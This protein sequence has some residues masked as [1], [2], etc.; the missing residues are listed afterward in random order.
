MHQHLVDDDLEEQRRDQGEQLQE[1]RGDQ[2]LAQQAAVFVD[3]AQE[4]GD[5]EAAGEVRQAGAPRHQIEAAVPDRDELGPRHQVGP[6]RQRRLDQDLVVAGLAEDQE[7]AVAQRRDGGQGRRG[8]PRPVG[9][10]RARLEAE[11]LGAA[12]HFRC[13]DL[14]VP[15]RC[16]ICPGSAATPWK[17]SSVTRASSPGS[18]G[19]APSGSVLMRALR[20]TSRS[21]VRLR[22]QRRLVRRRIGNR[23]PALAAAGR[24]EARRHELAQQGGPATCGAGV[25]AL[26]RMLLPGPPSR[27]SCPPPPISTSSPLPPVSVSLPGLPIRT[28]SPSPPLAVS[29]MPAEP[30]RRR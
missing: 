9:P 27:T 25:A 15:S 21:G 24:D 6:R 5:V 29:S 19:L 1:E 8:E 20:G 3:R 16:L 13:A 14:V 11:I 22:Q 7:A 2:H 17:R 4:P 12:E 10:A 23:R 28:S 18:A 30:R 26:R